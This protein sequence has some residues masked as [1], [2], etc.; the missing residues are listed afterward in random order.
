MPIISFGRACGPSNGAAD[1]PAVTDAKGTLTRFAFER[2]SDA[3]AYCLA[4]H[5][6]TYGDF[7]AITGG[8]TADF[9]AAAFGIWKLGAVPLVIP[10]SRT[11]EEMRGL[12]ELGKPKL[13]I[14]FPP[15][16]VPEIRQIPLKDAFL[17]DTSGRPR[18]PEILPPNFRVGASGGSTGAP[19]L[20]VVESPAAGD[21]APMAFRYET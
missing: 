4:D 9:L 17:A 12:L 5:G 6:V 2:L 8:N 21:P 18:L 20:I 11:P 3:A 7:V 14:G 13:A 16:A 19:K 15:L 1:A 10:A